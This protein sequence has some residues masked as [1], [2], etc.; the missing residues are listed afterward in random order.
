MTRD[1]YSRMGGGYVLPKIR[2]M[3]K[4]LVKEMRTVSTIHNTI[5]QRGGDE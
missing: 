1:V 3:T 5:N 2:G 4:I